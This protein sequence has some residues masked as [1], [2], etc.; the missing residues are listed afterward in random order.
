[1][2]NRNFWLLWGNRA[3][4]RAAYSLSFFT[5]LIWVYQLT[6]SNSAVSLYMVMFFIASMA[7]SLV[8]GVAADLYDRRIIMILANLLWG[9]L[10]LAFVPAKNSF[11]FILVVTFVTQAL[12]EFFTPSQGSALPELVED[13]E[14]L[15]ANSIFYVVI[16]G[17]SFLGYFSSGI[18]L[19]FIGYSAPFFASAILV[20]SGAVLVLFL[21]PLDHK[22]KSPPLKE[23]GRRVKE[24][25]ID[26]LDFLFHNRHVTSNLI[27]MAVVFSGAAAAGALAPGF[28]EQVL[29]ID[30]RD[31]SFVGVAPLALGL[32]I[33]AIL[34][35][36][37]KK[38]WPVWQSIL[39]FGVTLLFLV[40]APILKVF[41][42]NHVIAPRA[43]ESIPVFSLAVSVL[44]LFLGFFAATVAVPT[45]TSIQR[46][47]PG[48]NLGR[49]FGSLGALSSILTILMVLGFGILADFFGP[50]V[51]VMLVSVLAVGTAFL[52]RD[53]VVIK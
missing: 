23:F 7:F 14:L 46:V 29:K 50:S 20:L 34:L 5:L 26:Q 53:K 10:I 48:R 9:I 6:G 52:I 27:L 8:A 12:D 22:E 45:V 19:R 49:T 21:P 11:P 24:G 17:A 13:R 28:A 15:K 36:R 30:A 38:S 47:T 40:S 25:L 4:T 37:I 41:F 35:G 42:S 51:P 39:G 18:L 3:F 16:Y 1:M 43:F 31:L 33:G 44:I 32:L 2:L